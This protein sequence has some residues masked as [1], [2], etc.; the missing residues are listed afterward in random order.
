MCSPGFGR[1]SLISISTKTKEVK[2]EKDVRWNAFWRIWNNNK[3]RLDRIGTLPS[4]T[5]FSKT[6]IT[7]CKPESLHSSGNYSELIKIPLHLRA[8]ICRRVN[9]RA[10][11]ERSEKLATAPNR[12]VATRIAQH[13]ISCEWKVFVDIFQFINHCM[14]SFGRSL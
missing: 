1:E 2:W 3:F 12:S 7:R 5:A 13:L 11:S 14:F 6:S 4:S 10:A 8:K 9:Q